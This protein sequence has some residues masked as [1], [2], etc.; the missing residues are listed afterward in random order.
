M[1]S[2]RNLIKNFKN[3]Y[4]NNF[5][6]IHLGLL[7]APDFFQSKKFCLI[8]RK[9]LDIAFLRSELIYLLVKGKIL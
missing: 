7:D 3:K 8:Q 9:I 6:V 4:V 1:T 2:F 5:V